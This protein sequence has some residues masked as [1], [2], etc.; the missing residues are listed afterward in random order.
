MDFCL[1]SPHAQNKLES[2]LAH[3]EYLVRPQDL[4]CP[5]MEILED[6]FNVCVERSMSLFQLLLLL[7]TEHV[8]DLVEVIID[9]ARDKL[10][11]LIIINLD[12][13]LVLRG[14]K[15]GFRTHK[16]ATVELIVRDAEEEG[17]QTVE[18]NGVNVLHHVEVS[19]SLLFTF[20]LLVLLN[21]ILVLIISQAIT[22]I[23]IIVVHFSHFLSVRKK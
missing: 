10:F 13:S 20:L 11:T 23:D 12:T 17:V 2:S 19:L 7:L 1:L 15:I 16:F 9:V 6:L 22:I 18:K 14:I 21:V 4:N 5:L 8:L 3:L